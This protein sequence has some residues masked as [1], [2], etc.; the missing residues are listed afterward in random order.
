MQILVLN[1]LIR[2]ADYN[3]SVCDFLAWYKGF[4]IVLTVPPYVVDFRI[5]SLSYR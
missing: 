4:W 1:F 5:K 2:N 3:L